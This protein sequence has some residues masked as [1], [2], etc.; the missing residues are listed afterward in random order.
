[1][2][3][4][5]VQPGQRRLQSL[6]NPASQHFAGRILQPLDI[7]EVMMV[8]LVV[9]RCESG[10]DIAE[11]HHPAKR[12][13]RLALQMDFDAKR[14]TVKP[15]A[16]VPGRHVGQAVRGFDL[17]NLKDVHAAILTGRTRAPSGGGF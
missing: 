14:M 7:V 9:E 11:V 16:F 1:M 5:F 12:G 10:F 3:H 13:I 15:R 2:D 4:Y 6:P 17:E 8:E